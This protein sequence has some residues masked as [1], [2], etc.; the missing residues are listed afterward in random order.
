MEVGFLTACMRDESLEDIIAWAGEAGVARLEVTL[1]HL[2][3]DTPE[4]DEAV[5]QALDAAG[6]GLSSVAAYDAKIL[7]DPQKGLANL[8]AAIDRCAR[9]GT[10]VCCALAGIA[11][12]GMT[13]EDAIEGPFTDIFGPAS[14]HAEQA[15]VTIA[16]ENWFATL[17]MH[18]DHWDHVLERVPSARLGFNYD[19]S[20]LAWQGIDYLEG[21]EVYA[22]RIV[23]THAKDTEIRD[24][25]RRRIGVHGKGWWR[26]CIPGQG[27]IR[28]GEYIARLRRIGYDGVLSI[29]HEDGFLGAK[30]GVLLGKRYLEQFI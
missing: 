10:D 28:W 27:C 26:Y 15:G 22:S 4:R 2:G 30:E 11:P 13:R 25:V 8:K 9:L 1:A 24:D 29:E 12:E 17:I 7:E 5:Q 19:P 14:E 3:N 18:F 6:V 16:L 20:H 21:V 23:H